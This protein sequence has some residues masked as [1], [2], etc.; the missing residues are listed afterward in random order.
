MII[1]MIIGIHNVLIFDYILRL[2]THSLCNICVY[3]GYTVVCIVHTMYNY[4]LCKA[5][6]YAV[7]AC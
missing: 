5:S 4:N 1:D 3:H 2:N 7:A 6:I